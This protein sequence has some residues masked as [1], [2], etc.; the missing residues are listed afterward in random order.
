MGEFLLK[1]ITSDINFRKEIAPRYEELHHANINEQAKMARAL[2]VG[3]EKY[4]KAFEIAGDA[5][6]DLELK[7]DG[8]TDELSKYGEIDEDKIRRIV[9]EKKKSEGDQVKNER[10]MNVLKRTYNKSI[11]YY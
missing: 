9:E 3:K 8:L 6:N 11:K 4:Q 2:F 5:I 7:C 10:I 1:Q